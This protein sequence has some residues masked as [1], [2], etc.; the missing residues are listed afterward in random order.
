[1]GLTG[2]SS[3][4]VKGSSAET[5]DVYSIWEGR[6][7]PHWW[8]EFFIRVGIYTFATVWILIHSPCIFKAICSIKIKSTYQGI[9]Y[10]FKKYFFPPRALLHVG[11]WLCSRGQ[12]Y[13]RPFIQLTFLSNIASP[14]RVF[15]CWLQSISDWQRL[16]ENISSS[17]WAGETADSSEQ[18]YI[19]SICYLNSIGKGL[20]YLIQVSKVPLRAL[21]VFC[22]F[23]CHTAV[24]EGNTFHKDKGR[25]GIIGGLEQQF[26]LFL[27]IS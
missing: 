19:T 25:E 22:F 4:F 24:N 26:L 10:R 5:S 18:S 15:C 1:M 20:R 13:Y 6:T 17:S 2:R 14:G 27:N 7:S 3:Q 16:H 9:L 21:N 12:R 23:L 11:R 8:D